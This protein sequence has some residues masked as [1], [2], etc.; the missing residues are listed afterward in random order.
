MPIHCSK[1]EGNWTRNSDTRSPS[2]CLMLLVIYMSHHVTD[3]Q[4]I[5]AGWRPILR[6]NQRT[7]IRQWFRRARAFAHSSLAP[8]VALRR[9]SVILCDLKVIIPTEMIIQDD[10]KL[11]G[12]TKASMTSMDGLPHNRIHSDHIYTNIA[13]INTVSPNT[14]ALIVTIRLS[15]N[16][17]WSDGFL[18]T[19][20]FYGFVLGLWT[21]YRSYIL[22]SCTVTDYYNCVFAS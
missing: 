13:I 16:I 6:P 12:A 3:L 9:V 1:S 11:A 15:V 2:Q 8:F 19:L 20:T 10:V 18:H 21:K 17:Y 5:I 7:K 14:S 22:P 4:R